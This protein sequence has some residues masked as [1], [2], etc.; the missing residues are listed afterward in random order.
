MCVCVCVCVCVRVR[1]CA[2]D[3]EVFTLKVNT[4]TSDVKIYTTINGIFLAINLHFC[5]E[6]LS[7]FT[8]VTHNSHFLY[9]YIKVCMA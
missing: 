8:V 2:V 7:V 3:C 6:V 4:P 9:H 5:T 1:A